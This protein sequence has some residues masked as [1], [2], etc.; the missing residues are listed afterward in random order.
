MLF[1]VDM[2]YLDKQAKCDVEK[3]FALRREPQ[4]NR[5]QNGISSVLCQN[6]E[7]MQFFASFSSE[8]EHFTHGM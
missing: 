6:K 8:Q 1:Y 2:I 5:N 3:S 4:P 7:S